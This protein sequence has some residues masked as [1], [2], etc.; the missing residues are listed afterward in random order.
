MAGIGRKTDKQPRLENLDQLF[1]LNNS[2]NLQESSAPVFVDINKLIPFS[3]HPFRLYE[4]ERFND[5]VESIKQN[6]VI[7]PIIVRSVDTDRYEIL[8]GHNRVEAA[9]SAG[10][11]NIPAVIREGL[12]DDE[13]LL[14]VTETNLIQ[15]SF[16]DLTHSERAAALSVRHEAIK[17]QGKRTDLINEIENLIRNTKNVS[18]NADN[19][20]FSP[21]AK[22]LNNV[23]KLGQSYGLSK[24]SVAR[25]LRV[26]KLIKELQKRVDSEEI[27]IRA[28]VEVSYMTSENQHDLAQ[29]LSENLKFK[30]DIKKAELLRE[31]SKD[32]KLTPKTIEDILAGV[33]FKKKNRASLPVQAFKI[34]GKVLSKYFKSGQTL[35][36]IEGEIV[37]AIEFYRKHKNISGD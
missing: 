24:D 31:F 33:A 13:A 14:I 23:A 22:K 4:G 29:I 17:S 18:N 26:N 27:S 5:M 20:T 11:E 15:R 2:E 7:I 3:K 21:V 30:I 10:L 9:K 25:Y 16:S 34:K 12:D 32:G 36:E 1:E 35:E 28:A 6:G 37:E 19:E 8:S